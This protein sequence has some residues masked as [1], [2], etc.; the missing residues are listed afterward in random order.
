MKKTLFVALMVFA[1]IAQA[2]VFDARGV[3]DKYVKMNE[4]YHNSETGFTISCGKVTKAEVK[5]DT[6]TTKV[7]VF[8]CSN[9][10]TYRIV[11]SHFQMWLGKPADKWQTS[12]FKCSDLKG[13]TIKGWQDPADW[14]ITPNNCKG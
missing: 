14:N 9:N 11:K 3:A 2:E 5:Q 1:G 7:Y 6:P 12:G 13:S 4:G 10:E 8:T